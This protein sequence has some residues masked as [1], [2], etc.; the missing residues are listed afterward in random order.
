MRGEFPIDSN[1]GFTVSMKACPNFKDSIIHGE[2]RWPQVE[3][4]ARN[5]WPGDLLA[6]VPEVKPSQHSRV[7]YEHM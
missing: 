4:K 1:V 7:C 3:K 5:Q 2:R 6:I